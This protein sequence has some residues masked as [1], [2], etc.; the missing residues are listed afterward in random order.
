MAEPTSS[1]D[2][3]DAPP[4]ENA[5][6]T[7]SPAA[8]GAPPRPAVAP[9]APGPDAPAAAAGAAATR[10]DQPPPPAPVEAQPTTPM[11]PAAEPTPPRLGNNRL[12]GTAWVL[13]AA[14][15]F[16]ALYLGAYALLIIALY[17]TQPLSA[18]M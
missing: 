18:A 1:P 12:V 14:G 2:G 5:D 15:I 8:T 11:P 9:A 7:T 16:E 6:T 13:L 4:V 3:A 17:G 10:G